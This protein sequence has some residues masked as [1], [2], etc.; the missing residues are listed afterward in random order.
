MMSM[1]SVVCCIVAC[2]VLLQGELYAQTSY[3]EIKKVYE[4]VDGTL[5]LDGY[6]QALKEMDA[7]AN[8][9]VSGI[10]DAQERGRATLLWHT[11]QRE[12]IFRFWQAVGGQPADLKKL[13][14]CQ[15]S[16]DPDV[17]ELELLSP[18][19]LK[20][21]LD[22][23]FRVN[24]SAASYVRMKE[25][26]YGIK[27]EKVRQTY[28]FGLL[29]RELQV[30]GVSKDLVPVF[31]VFRCCMKNRKIVERVN[32]LEKMYTPVRENAPAPEI[33]LPDDKGNTFRL[34]DFQ[35]KCVF[36]CVWALDSVNGADELD[37][38]A[39][40]KKVNE[41]W[42]EAG[43]V[44]VNIAVGAGE[45]IGKWRKILT[46][47]KQTEWMINLFCDKTKSAFVKDYVIGVL[48]RYIFVEI[49]GVLRSGW[50]ISPANPSLFKQV[51]TRNLF[52][53][54]RVGI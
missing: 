41:K 30:N 9:L 38:F 17:P 35:E 7:R 2:F 22:W 1:R 6:M 32:E 27:S 53:Y 42:G 5:S 46:E 48:P 13:H 40:A 52:M 33:V 10:D 34:T 54:K 49:D 15:L 11:Y 44:F 24:K 14:P 39:E 12:N 8:Q 21:V 19:E 3:P 26:L 23:Y 45:D 37:T 43:I 47:K 25:C 20:E 36:I 18:E 16:M 51:F 28:A 29:E 4:H 31:E 50:F